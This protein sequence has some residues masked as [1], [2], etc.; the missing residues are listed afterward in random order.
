MRY[1][2]V[3]CRLLFENDPVSFCVLSRPSAFR[4][5]LFCNALFCNAHFSR[6]L[7]RRRLCRFVI[8]RSY[9]RSGLTR[10]LGALRH[11]QRT[12]QGTRRHNGR[13]LHPS[14]RR[15]LP[16]FRGKASRMKRGLLADTELRS[17]LAADRATRQEV[18]VSH[19]S[20][21]FS[22]SRHE[23]VA[24]KHW[25]VHRCVVVVHC[26]SLTAAEVL[27]RYASET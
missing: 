15:S 19:R 13:R 12:V 3:R 7:K 9:L 10:T 26:C 24:T 11:P 22:S 23:R 2:A 1:P 25:F 20:P 16:P 5:Q 6:A 21:L 14:R 17:R 18:A 8:D 4:P 27:R